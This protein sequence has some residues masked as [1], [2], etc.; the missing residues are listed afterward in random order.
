[1]DYSKLIKRAFSLTL[2]NRLLWILGFFVGVFGFGLNLPID[3]QQLN[4]HL[5]LSFQNPERAAQ[6]VSQHLGLTLLCFILFLMVSLSLLILSVASE[7]GLIAAVLKLQKGKTVSLPEALNQGLRVI[8]RILGL[9][10]LMGL[11]FF[12]LSFLPFYLASFYLSQSAGSVNLVL[13]LLFGFAFLYSLL[14]LLPLSWCAFRLFVEKGESFWEGIKKATQ[15]VDRFFKET[16]LLLLL[17]SGI[18]FGLFLLMSLCYALN[19]ALFAGLGSALM[20]KFGSFATL[21]LLL[22]FYL[23]LCLLPIVL[24]AFSAAFNSALITLFYLEIK[25][26]L[27]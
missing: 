6:W 7:G 22:P 16:L 13:I 21:L 25:N 24:F 15:L 2:K 11:W 4:Q 9:R 17:V 8:W 10:A 26:V 20:L 1:M 12:F 14:Y 27:D 18:G 23:P 3:S 19:D 5:N